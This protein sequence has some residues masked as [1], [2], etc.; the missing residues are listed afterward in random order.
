MGRHIGIVTPVFNDWESFTALVGEIVAR[1]RGGDIVFHVLAVDDGSSARFD[2][3]A[4]AVVPDGCIAEIEVLGLALNLGHQRAIASGLCAVADRRDIEAVIVMDSDGEDRPD[5]IAALLAAA[6]RNTGQ[7]VLAHRAKRS[8][9]RAFRFWYAIYKLLFHT[10]TGRA[11]SFGNYALLPMSAVQRLV[12][13]PELWNNL[14][15][16]IMR[17]RLPYMTVATERGTRYAGRSNMNMVALVVH[18]L[19]AMSVYVDMIFVR[20]LMAAGV[21]AALSVLGI[22]GI[23]LIRVAT[24]LA[25]PGWATVAVGDLFIVLLQ[26]VVIVIAT[27]LMMLAGRSSRPII[28]IVDAW[29]FIAERRRIDSGRRTASRRERVE[30]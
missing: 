10:L 25:I 3:D 19:S 17:S 16:S 11:I 18:G 2:S 8:E 21:V 29:P 27:S 22:I 26:T 5:D 1:F 30:L 9:T 20:V 4:M 13:M 6:E 12:H 24:D 14:A 7:V 23:T 15:A 28:P